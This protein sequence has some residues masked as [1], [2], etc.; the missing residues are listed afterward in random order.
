MVASLVK[1]AAQ[2]VESVVKNAVAV[3]VDLP[4]VGGF[5]E[6]AIL[7]AMNFV[8]RPWSSDSCGFT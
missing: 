5:N 2:S 7:P 1:D 8:T 3:E 6:S 4:A